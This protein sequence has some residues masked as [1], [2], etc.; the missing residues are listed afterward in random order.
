MYTRCFVLSLI[1]IVG[2][3]CAGCGSVA[4][5]WTNTADRNSTSTA[6]VGA[7]DL[8]PYVG[9]QQKAHVRESTGIYAYECF[10]DLDLSRFKADSVHLQVAR[11]A[12]RSPRFRAIVAQLKALPEGQRKVILVEARNVGHPTWAQLGRITS[13][14]SGQTTAGQAAEELI[15][16][17]IVRAA[18]EVLRE[19][20]R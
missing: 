4:E 20:D 18:E 15:A 10:T 3:S 1:F 8:I 11:E 16:G 12:K 7:Q 19:P 6:D 5:R 2:L 9:T 17:A 14:G 13:D